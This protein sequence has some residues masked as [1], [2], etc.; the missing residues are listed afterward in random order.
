MRGWILAVVGAE[1]KKMGG[2]AAAQV[3]PWK[4]TSRR[5]SR[6][7]RARAQFDGTHATI[8]TGT[9]APKFYLFVKSIE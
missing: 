6:S 5:I 2:R 8:V 9:L 3:D 7:Q 4:R 1:A